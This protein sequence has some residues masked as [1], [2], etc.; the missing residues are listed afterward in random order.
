MPSNGARFLSRHLVVVLCKTDALGLWRTLPKRSTGGQGPLS[1][2]F[3]NGRVSLGPD[4]S[5]ADMLVLDA[6]AGYS[7]V[8]RS[9]VSYSNVVVL[10]LV[11]PMRVISMRVIRMFVSYSDIGCSNVGYLVVF[12]HFH[13]ISVGN[14]STAY[15]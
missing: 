15:S 4:V 3:T 12:W 5:R 10:I 6:N 9:N 2:A 13:F 11:I 8:G 1:G 14:M 7:D